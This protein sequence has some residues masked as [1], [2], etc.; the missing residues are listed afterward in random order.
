MSPSTDRTFPRWRQRVLELGLNPDVDGHDFPII[1]HT[2]SLEEYKRWWAFPPRSDAKVN[3]VDPAKIATIPDA[4][5]RRYVQGHITNERVFT[6]PKSIRALEKRVGRFFVHVRVAPNRVCTAQ[7]PIIVNSSNDITVYDEITIKDGG[8]IE[9][10]SPCKFEAQVITKIQGGASGRKYDVYV[11]GNPGRDASDGDSPAAAPQAAPG[12][13]AKCDCCGGAI[14]RKA[15]NGADGKPGTNGFDATQNATAGEEGPVVFFFIHESFRGAGG[16]T[17]LNQGGK[18][19]DGGRG[20][21]GAEGQRGGDG[22]AGARCGG[23]TA[24]GGDGGTGGRGG[25]GGNG[26]NGKNGGNGGR[27][28]IWVPDALY[29]DMIVTNGRAPG[30]LAG[31]KGRYGIGGSGGKGGSHGGKHGERGLDGPSDGEPGRAGEPGEPGSS[32]VNDRMVS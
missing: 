29:S 16:L 3:K 20:G 17:F 1:R 27:L 4:L 32:Y 5:V 31:A 13:D 2:D 9:I 26:S 12:R 6:N 14:E 28:S 23:V 19:G 25:G 30:G 24:R 15:T 7:D 11:V 22:G 10:T 8:Y 21:N 18:G